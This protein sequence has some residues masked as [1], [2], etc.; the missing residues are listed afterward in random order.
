MTKRTL[1]PIPPEPWGSRLR[2]ARE[3]VAHLTGEQAVAHLGEYVSSSA[4]TVSR[5][6][7]SPDVPH[8]RRTRE[9]AI[10]LCYVYGVDPHEL[11]LNPEE[12]PPKMRAVTP[13]GG[14]RRPLTSVA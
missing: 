10:L 13:G 1:K 4:S 7:H 3:D 6:E 5:L 9:K 12:L 11:D 14:R 8:Q 2:R